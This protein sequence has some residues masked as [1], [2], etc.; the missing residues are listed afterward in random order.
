MTSIRP[1][2]KGAKGKLG[3]GRE[4]RRGKGD[5]KVQE[6]KGNV[7][8]DRGDDRSRDR[9]GRHSEARCRKGRQEK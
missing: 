1:K 4:L 7:C 3:K 8:I 2:S 9:R 6:E 5:L